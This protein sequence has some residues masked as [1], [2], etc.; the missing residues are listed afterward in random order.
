MVVESNDDIVDLNNVNVHRRLYDGP[1]SHYYSMAQD[2]SEEYLEDDDRPHPR[3]LQRLDL[4]SRYSYDDS[5]DWRSSQ[6]YRPTYDDSDDSSRPEQRYRS[7]YNDNTRDDSQ[8]YRSSYDSSLQQSTY[9]RE[10]Q[11]RSG[12]FYDLQRSYNTF[13]S[14]GTSERD[15][16]RAVNFGLSSKVRVEKS[17]TGKTSSRAGTGR[18]E[19]PFEYPLNVKLL[20][21][22]NNKLLKGKFCDV[23][24]GLKNMPEGELIKSVGQSKKKKKQSRKKKGES[25]LFTN[26]FQTEKFDFLK[27]YFQ[28]SVKW[29]HFSVS[30]AER[31][32][33]LFFFFVEYNFPNKSLS[34]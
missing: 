8:R 27:I 18:S 17:E 33:F 30:L 28:V 23:D 20:G 24:D 14:A 12:P 15:V 2:F 9:E 34:Y 13:S 32:F 10:V 21:Q 1:N 19:P 26:K 25:C 22:A 29:A 11:F 7:T 31:N 16:D 6:R 3:A 5:D 4:H